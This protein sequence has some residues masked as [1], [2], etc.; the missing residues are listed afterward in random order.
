MSNRTWEWGSGVRG[1]IKEGKILRSEIQKSSTVQRFLVSPRLINLAQSGDESGLQRGRLNCCEVRLRAQA[2]WCTLCQ[3]TGSWGQ[4]RI[5]VQGSAMAPPTRGPSWP[6]RDYQPRWPNSQ[7]AEARSRKEEWT[8]AQE[9]PS[10]TPAP[11][12]RLGI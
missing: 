7:C 6:L 5:P 2:A 11:G 10:M 4:G 3:M 9:R 1:T 12:N 8:V